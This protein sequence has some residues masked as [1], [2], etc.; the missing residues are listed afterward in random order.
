MHHPDSSQA[1]IT[2]AFMA[3]IAWRLYARVRRNIGRQKLSPRRPWITLVIFPVVVAM[4]AFGARALV[5]SEECLAAG[6]ALGIVL[7]VIGQRLTKYEST[8]EGRFYTP[9]AHLGIALS[10]VLVARLA[11][12]FMVIGIPGTPGATPPPNP[13]SPL[14]MLIVGTLA[15]YYWTYALGLVRWMLRTPAQTQSPPE[16]SPL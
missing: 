6:L 16:G 3:L 13:W 10:A 8:P 9:S 14:T 5:Q 1:L 4:L 12:R 11:Y 7:G 15:G 2:I